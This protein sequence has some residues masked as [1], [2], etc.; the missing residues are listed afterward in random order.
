M[1]STQNSAHPAVATGISVSADPVVVDKIKVVIKINGTFDFEHENTRWGQ[2][3]L[4]PFPRMT[5]QFSTAATL[6][7]K[8]VSPFRLIVFRLIVFSCSLVKHRPGCQCMVLKA[9]NLAHPE[10]P[11]CCLHVSQ[12]E[13]IW[14]LVES[15]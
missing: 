2:I 5:P 13:A 12:T 4:T 14:P 7:T 9:G 1:F 10:Y 3:I 11:K 6:G 8:A 15:A